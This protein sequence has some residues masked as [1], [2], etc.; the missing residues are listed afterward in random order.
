MTRPDVTCVMVTQPA[1]DELAVR[2]LAC[3][4]QQSLV[5]AELLVVSDW[6]FSE[7]PQLTA[8]T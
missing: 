7:M 8:A 6:S 5:A 4:M 3:F 2:A 1:R